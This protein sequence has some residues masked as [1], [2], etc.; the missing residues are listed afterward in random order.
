M[1][2]EPYRLFFPLGLIF[3][4][5][6]ASVWLSQIWG[7]TVYPVELHRTLVLN[8]FVG[9]FIGGF[10]MTAIPQFS[11]TRQASQ[12]EVFS[13]FF[14][15]GAL[16]FLALMKL[17]YGVS[18]LSA[19][20]S[21]L[22]LSFLAP[23]IIQRKSN[24]P[25]TFI[26][27]FLGLL[28]WLM[29]GLGQLWGHGP[30]ELYKTLQHEA[31]IAALILGVGA[32]LIPGILGH[33]E[34]VQAQK[35]RYENVESLLKT[36]PFGFTLLVFAFVASY[37]LPDV[38]A[39]WIQAGVVTLIATAHWRIH[40]FPSKRTHLTW[41]LWCCALS[42]VLSFLFQ[43]LLGQAHIHI[44]HAFFINGVVLISLL[45]ATRVI[46]AHGPGVKIEDSRWV[47]VMTGLILLASATRVSAYFLPNSYFTH[48]GYSSFILVLALA[49]WGIKFL[50]YTR[51]YPKKDT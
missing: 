2:K 32:R 39:Q 5:W 43:P 14:I 8:G 21:I 12:F 22:L 1:I 25:Y 48:L 40:Q 33:T 4:V 26:F 31:A 46:C 35:E 20:Q 44:A 51:A 27:V 28:L 50:P 11:Q 6:G 36:I 49:I 9:S 47:S 37:F 13:Y 30:D 18:A 3:L 15:T 10:L 7:S 17:P 19:L 29:A 16:P 24:P 23:R 34:I 41:S 42:I 45:V 38:Q